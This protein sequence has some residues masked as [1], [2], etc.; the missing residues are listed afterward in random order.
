MN[1]YTCATLNC[2]D[3]AEMPN[4]V[5][6][7]EKPRLTIETLLTEAAVFAVAE[8]THDEPA[9]YG[10]TDGKGGWPTHYIWVPHS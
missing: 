5:I 9:L 1:G 3:K 10:V 4:Q 8:S 6:A 2:E 7:S